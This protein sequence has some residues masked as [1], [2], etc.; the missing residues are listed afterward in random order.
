M[1][2][3]GLLSPSEG[4]EQTLLHS[5]ICSVRDVMKPLPHDALQQAC[6]TAVC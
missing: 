6:V 4:C 5:S 2:A 1:L 3:L